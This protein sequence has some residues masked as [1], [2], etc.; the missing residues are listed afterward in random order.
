MRKPVK[1]LAVLSA[2]MLSLGG[3]ATATAGTGTALPT[4][5]PEH[6]G[7]IVC[8]ETGT[9][10]FVVWDRTCPK[11]H[12]WA[13]IPAQDVYG[14]A[15]APAAP[16][17]GG[18]E[19]LTKSVKVDDGQVLSG[20]TAVNIAQPAGSVLLAVGSDAQP[21]APAPQVTVGLPVV[22]QASVPSPVAVATNR[23]FTLD[24]TPLNPGT[25]RTVT[26]WLLVT[27]R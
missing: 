19:Y 24:G 9:R 23:T 10:N 1:I 14:L 4:P 12:F 20:A 26:V 15:E 17:A 2:V 5:V 7:N 13:Q 6:T 8:V 3:A 22:A 16:V 27:R 25:S 21:A 11:N 18:T